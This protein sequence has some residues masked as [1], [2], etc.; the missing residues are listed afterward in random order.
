MS[1]Q[2]EILS[3]PFC[4]KSTISCI[5]FPSATSLKVRSTAT[6]GRS[7]KRSKSKDTWIVKTG[8]N[9]CNKSIGEVEAKLK[10]QGYF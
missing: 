1:A 3:C 2:Y 8:C 4:S 7:V 5:Y 9:S 10:E 6:F